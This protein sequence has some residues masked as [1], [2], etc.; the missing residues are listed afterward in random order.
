MKRILLIGVALM[1]LAA[2]GFATAGVVVTGDT[3]GSVAV[4]QSLVVSLNDSFSGPS[5]GLYPYAPCD[6][7]AEAVAHGQFGIAPLGPAEGG[8]GWL[9]LSV[10]CSNGTWNYSGSHT[11]TVPADVG[12]GE[13]VSVAVQ[14]FIPVQYSG[15]QPSPCVTETQYNFN[16]TY[17][18]ITTST[19][20]S[21]AS[22]TGQTTTTATVTGQTSTTA[23]GG[24]T[25]TSTTPSGSTTQAT[26][27]ASPVTVTQGT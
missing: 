19:P 21:T 2:A 24:T 1:G 14:E 16:Q 20:S 5:G 3:N 27:T 26:V 7:N 10:S 11:S 23:T 13:W 4:G 6:P 18:V 8:S 22:V 9:P 15:C 12:P 25:T 17:P